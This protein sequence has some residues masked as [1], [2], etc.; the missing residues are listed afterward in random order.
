M[1]MCVLGVAFAV[2]LACLASPASAQP[3]NDTC[4]AAQVV[5][6]N[7]TVNGNNINANTDILQS[8]C[9]DD[10]DSYDVWYRLTAAVPGMYTFDTIGSAMP[11]TTLA[12]Y[13]SCPASGLLGC[14]DDID[15]DQGNFWSSV[16]LSLFVTQTVYIRVAGYG[17]DEGQFRLNI[18][19]PSASSGICCR[20]STC[21]TTA[22]L[23]TCT[24]PNTRF[25]QAAA[26][27]APGNNLVPC[28]H[29]D[30]NKQSGITVQDVFD[31]LTA[32]FSSSPDANMTGNGN[33]PPTVQSIFDFLAAWFV[34]GC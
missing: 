24:G 31:F 22:T 1:R 15:F 18:Q 27:N 34:G 30:F 2:V 19:G 9:T 26:C 28:C 6:A 4:Q 13:G 8:P 29:A 16:Q 3:A 5:L 21:A 25:V 10:L 14:N 33:G 23:A 11:D 12:I 17:L 20:G 32:W 7:T